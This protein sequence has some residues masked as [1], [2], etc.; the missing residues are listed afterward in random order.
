M[1]KKSLFVIA[2]T[3]STLVGTGIISPSVI[4]TQKQVSAGVNVDLGVNQLV[5]FARYFWR[6]Y[7][8]ANYRQT[9]YAH[10]PTQAV[11]NIKRQYGTSANAIF[12]D[13]CKQTY[14]RWQNAQWWQKSIIDPFGWFFFTHREENGVVNCYLR[15]PQR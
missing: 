11:Q 7:Y 13:G 6:N 2:L 8:A 10:Y 9:Y 14:Y 4:N 15:A 5:D 1:L 12:H 3:A